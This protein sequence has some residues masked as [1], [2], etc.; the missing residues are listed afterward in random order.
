MT[1][2]F[3]VT[4]E[5]PVDPHG[6]TGFPRLGGLSLDGLE[7]FLQWALPLL[8]RM[9]FLREEFED[10][11]LGDVVVRVWSTD[12]D[13][14]LVVAGSSPTSMDE[15]ASF[16]TREPE[17]YPESPFETST[18]TSGLP[19]DDDSYDAGYAVGEDP[20]NVIY[21]TEEEKHGGAE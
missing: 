15:V 14:A 18:V 16:L 2:N 8:A 11:G 13:A 7:L 19:V 1:T 21:L 10:L 9:Q 12:E 20:G 4:H 6:V 17:G 3:S 5:E